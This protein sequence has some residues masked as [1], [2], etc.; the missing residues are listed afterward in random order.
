MHNYPSDITRE[1]FE[2]IRP[3]LE[4][5]RER[6]RPRKYDLYDIYC[7]I[8]Y[9]VKSGCQWRMIP[10]DFPPFGVVRYYY[11][12]W[13]KEESGEESLLSAALKKIENN[14]PK[15]RSAKG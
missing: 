14:V 11:D 2:I 9:L 12:I 1:Q 13:G 6:T 8:Q 3:V 7:A 10:G 5:V 15:S 4:G